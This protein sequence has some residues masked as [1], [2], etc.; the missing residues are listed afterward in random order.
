MSSNVTNPPQLISTINTVRKIINMIKEKQGGIYL[1]YGDGDF[2]IL[3]GQDDMLAICTPTFQYWIR[4]GM[5]LCDPYVLTCIPH[6]CP[7][8]GTLE[9]GMFG[10]NHEYPLHMVQEF[11]NKLSILQN[12]IPP[13]L[14][15][16]IAL[17]FC[18]V[19]AADIVVE[20]HKELK[21]QHIIFIGNQNYSNEY[22]SKLF[23]TSLQRIHTPA[24]DSYMEH[25]RVV[26][27]FD[28]LY[29]QTYHAFDFFVIIMAA[30]CGGRAFTAELYN[31]YPSLNFFILDYGSLLDYMWGENSRAYMTLDPPNAEYILRSI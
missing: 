3:S 19:H 24:R 9:T 8:L 13:I 23:G 17:S 26:S 20:L 4:E 28:T 25:D 10:G 16:N 27:E 12:G 6:H 21:K 11:I 1:R 31:K 2:N 5:K 15:S 29:Q 18:A 7:E 30:G 22:L 14:Y